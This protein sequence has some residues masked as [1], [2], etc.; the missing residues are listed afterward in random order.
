[1]ANH[2][3]TDDELETPQTGSRWNL[4]FYAIFFPVFIGLIWLAAWNLGHFRERYL[5][6]LLASGFWLLLSGFVC[7][8]ACYFEPGSVR[9]CFINLLGQFGARQFAWIERS[10]GESPTVCFGYELWGRRF[11]YV[12]VRADRI[13]SVDWSTGQ[14]TWMAKQD[15]DDW[16]VWVR[17]PP[18]SQS[19]H[20]PRFAAD[21]QRLHSVGTC[22]PK[23]VI[24][25][26]GLTVVKFLERAGVVMVPSDD[27]CRYSVV[28][29]SEVSHPE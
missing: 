29:R 20:R 27:G 18:E 12:S 15:M 17:F 13:G 5:V 22:G 9:Q 11:K 6:S 14:A 28:G 1:M 26:F 19:E 16:C 25:A 21:Q 3:S 24:A 4:V 7:F 8:G 23:V 2:I 10:D